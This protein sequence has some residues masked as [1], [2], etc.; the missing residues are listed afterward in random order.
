M[1]LHCGEELVGPGAIAGEELSNLKIEVNL[2]YVPGHA[3]NKG[4]FKADHAEGGVQGILLENSKVG[5]IIET[6]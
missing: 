5:R 2:R 4:N 1:G 3:G 6:A